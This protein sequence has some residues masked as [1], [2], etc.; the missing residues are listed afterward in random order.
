MTPTDR[1]NLRRFLVACRHDVAHTRGWSDADNAAWAND[2]LAEAA[3]RYL[4]VYRE[5]IAQGNEEAA[6]AAQTA[7]KTW[8]QA[9]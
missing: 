1:D 5:A 4:G 9:S 8:A 7:I 6:L 3:D 2:H